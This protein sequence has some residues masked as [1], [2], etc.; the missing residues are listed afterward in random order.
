MS[1]ASARRSAYLAD[2]HSAINAL[3]PHQGLALCSA[4]TRLRWTDRLLAIVAVL[5]SFVSGDTLLDRFQAARHTQLRMYPGRRRT[6]RCHRGFVKRLILR[7][8]ALLGIITTHLRQLLEKQAVQHGC[9]H[10]AGLAVFGVDSTALACPRTQANRRGLG[11]T[12]TDDVHVQLLM[13]AIFHVGSNVLWAFTRD[14]ARGSERAALLSMLHLLP[15]KSLLLADAGFVGYAFFSAL[16]TSGRHFLVRGG[17]HLQFLRGLGIH[18]RLHGDIV[19]LW[20]DKR[21]KRHQPPIVLRLLISTDSRNRRVG[22]L[23]SVLD[24]RQLSDQRMLQLYA[25]RWSVELKYRTLKQVMNRRKLLSDSPR[26][27]E[28]EADFTLLG[29]WML[30]H[31][32][33]ATTGRPERA[34]AHLLRAIRQCISGVADTR[35]TTAL[36]AARLDTCYRRSAKRNTHWPSNKRPK[37]QLPPQARMATPREVKLAQRL[38]AFIFAA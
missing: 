31:M 14:R 16:I 9:W 26:A 2:L 36:H 34:M 38:N 4:D 1:P 6:G 13:T 3:L 21:R 15:D 12:G 37:P 22:L 17:S 25:M 20:P 5:M 19:Y 33:F 35:L 10:T 11:T 29:L 7:G 8:E 24:R 32:H 30:E 27:A 18:A 28:V 23:T